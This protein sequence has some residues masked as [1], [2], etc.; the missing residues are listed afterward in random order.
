M[1]SED[2]WRITPCYLS[3]LE[4]QMVL[5]KLSSI[6]LSGR[7]CKMAKKYFAF[8]GPPLYLTIEKKSFFLSNAAKRLSQWLKKQLFEFH[9][10]NHQKNPVRESRHLWSDSGARGK[11]ISCKAGGQHFAFLFQ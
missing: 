4:S 5:A 2:K 11:S 1:Y 3:G 8:G 9:C 10:E 6:Q 7:F